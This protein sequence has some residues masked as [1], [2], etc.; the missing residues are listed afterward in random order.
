MSYCPACGASLPGDAAFC[1]HCGASVASAVQ[2]LPPAPVAPPIPMS[3]PYAP[4]ADQP[5]A[6]FPPLVV[7]FITGPAAP[8]PLPPDRPGRL[9]AYP[10]RDLLPA[11]W[12]SAAV[13]G[14]LLVV[15]TVLV[16]IGS[17]IW[18]PDGQ[19]GDLGIWL[20]V[21]MLLIGLAAGG[22]ITGEMGVDGAYGSAALHAMPFLLTAL[23]LVPIVLLARREER[24]RPA[25]RLTQTA[26]A[27]THGLS[28]AILIGFAELFATISRDIEGEPAR[29]GPDIAITMVTAFLLV[30][31]ASWLARASA[32]ALPA[33]PV[34][35]E[36]VHAT[37]L[38]SFQLV[39]V[40]IGAAGAGVAVVATHLAGEDDLGDSLAGAIATGAAALPTGAL[41]ILGVPVSASGTASSSGVLSTI[42]NGGLPGGARDWSYGLITDPSR[43]SLLL[44]IPV[45]ATVWAAIRSVLSRPVAEW[46]PRVDGGVIAGTAGLAAAL[47]LLV[48]LI[49]RASASV[50]IGAEAGEDAS[51]GSYAVHAGASLPAAVLAG[52]IWGALA[53][54][55]TRWAP[56][57]ALA[58]PGVVTRL[59]GRIDDSWRAVLDG[60]WAP[61]PAVFSPVLANRIVAAF[62][63]LVVLVAVGATA[64][65]VMGSTIFTPSR[66]AVSYL[67]AIGRGDAGA[68]LAMLDTRPPADDRLLLTDTALRTS[69]VVRPTGVRAGSTD[70]DDDRATVQLTFKLGAADHEISL[71]MYADPQRKHAAGLPEWRV[72]SALGRIAAGTTG[73][74]LSTTVAGVPIG[75][76]LAAFPGVYPATVTDPS[77]M[78]QSAD[79]TVAVTDAQEDVDAGNLA[80]SE[81]TKNAINAAVHTQIDAC[82]GGATNVSCPFAAYDIPGYYDAEILTFTLVKR[83]VIRVVESYDTV[84]VQTVTEGQFA[85]D[86]TMEDADNMRGTRSLRAD[87][88]VDLSLPSAPTISFS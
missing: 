63:A 13:L 11:V 62:A 41:M 75:E 40:L 38:V 47:F 22:S 43:W 68:A 55:A 1:P 83:P 2:V 16:A 20:G 81:Q 12:Q 33:R 29:V 56:S 52:L 3:S 7:P 82:I 48:A 14:A 34:L 4:V 73:S 58:A 21:A 87:G 36:L 74:G 85:Y 10:W 31:T 37:R 71:P 50:V 66:A 88:A 8:F 30:A 57:F 78:Y 69:G 72:T 28:A 42:F 45:A 26:R 49:Q 80:L 25:S 84:A 24:R 39:Y 19:H 54:L 79:T 65:S 59:P 27:A 35:R 51:I 5:P 77:G 15:T 17:A 6:P 86:F 70:E 60:R 64:V 61:P 53:A 44:L 46:R 18:L 32:T 67:Q 76:S 9:T 23:L